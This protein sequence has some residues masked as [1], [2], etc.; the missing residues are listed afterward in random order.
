LLD[1]GSFFVASTPGMQKIKAKI[2][3]LAKVDVPVLISG[4]SGSGREAVARLIHRLSNRAR[5][6]FGKVNCAALNGEL[7]EQELFG[8]SNRSTAPDKLGVLPVC[9][10]GTILL[11]EITH[12]HTQIQAQLLEMLQDHPFGTAHRTALD[13]RILASTTTAEYS[14]IQ[15]RLRDDFYDRLSAFT[16]H[17]P[18]LRE[19]RDELRILVAHFMDRL[20]RRYRISP[21]SFL[22][23]LW[24]AVEEHAWPGNLRELE[25]FVQRYLVMGDEHAAMDE[26]ASKPHLLRPSISTLSSDAPARGDA[27]G[28]K[29]LVRNIK[30]ETEK[31]A[32]TRILEKTRWNRKEAA[33]F[34]GISYRGLLYK[35]EQYELSPPPPEMNRKAIG[36]I[37]TTIQVRS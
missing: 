20:S 4:E 25:I 15:N 3:L 7:L 2:E 34:L 12:V 26:L 23:N 24:R 35:I 1:E 6:K 27:S 36:K 37:I 31:A 13:V 8:R 28:L 5:H 30:G 18:P 33:R 16:I 17:L 32:I 21:R 11:Q 9:D 19:R 14:A 22:D 29:S 10:G